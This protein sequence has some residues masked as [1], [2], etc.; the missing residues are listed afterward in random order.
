LLAVSLLL[1][2]AAGRAWALGEEQ[3]GNDP[4]SERNY[5]DWPGIMPLVN[6]QTRVYYNW[7]NGNEHMYYRG[8]TAALNAALKG[9]AAVKTEVREAAL[10]PGPAEARTFGGQKVPYNWNLHLV[11]GIARHLTTLAKGDQIWSTSPV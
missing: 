5:S 4:L 10:R 7:V 1:S 3:F 9:L 8:D 6:A 11:G 2:A